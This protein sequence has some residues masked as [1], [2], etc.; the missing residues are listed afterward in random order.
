MP[1]V[2]GEATRELPLPPLWCVAVVP[3][4]NDGI[5]SVREQYVGAH[6]SVEA[7]AGKAENRAVSDR[8][9]PDETPSI[10]VENPMPTPNHAKI[11][12]TLVDS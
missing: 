2:R 5:A 1:A 12:V 6:K 8:R 11:S 3:E 9:T 10:H 4:A 7:L